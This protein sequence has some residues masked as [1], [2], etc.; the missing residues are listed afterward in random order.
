MDVFSQFLLDI[1]KLWRQQHLQ[2]L[3]VEINVIQLSPV[4]LQYIEL[5][6]KLEINYWY[7]HIN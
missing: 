4:I 6:W 3:K 7:L 2:W 1:L 5:N